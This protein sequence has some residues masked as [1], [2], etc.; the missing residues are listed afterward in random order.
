MAITA[1]PKSKKP[2]LKKVSVK[3]LDAGKK[4]SKVKG[5]GAPIVSHTQRAG[6]C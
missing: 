1:K 5:G 4:S 6:N 2:D 3:D